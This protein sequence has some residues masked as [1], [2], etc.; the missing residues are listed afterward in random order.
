VISFENF[1]CHNGDL[2]AFE[3]PPPLPVTLQTPPFPHILPYRSPYH[4]PDPRGRKLHF[5]A[6]K[7][8]ALR[9]HPGPPHFEAPPRQ[10]AGVT[11]SLEYIFGSAPPPLPLPP[12]TYPHGAVSRL[13]VNRHS[14]SL[15]RDL[16][17]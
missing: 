3:V 14:R 2:D 9:C 16:C 1:I 5:C 10:V 12:Y 4:I 7:K 6:R 13:R 15:A 8:K 11:H 17:Q